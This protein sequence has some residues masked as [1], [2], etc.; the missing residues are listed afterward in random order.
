M[1]Q[2]T[3]QTETYKG[4]GNMACKGSGAKKPKKGSKK[5]K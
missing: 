4:G 3:K 5:G 2:I 1:I